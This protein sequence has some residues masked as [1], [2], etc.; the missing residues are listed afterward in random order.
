MQGA[1]IAGIAPGEEMS[2]SPGNTEAAPVALFAAPRVAVERRTDGTILLRSPIPLRPPARCLGDWLV[3][4]AGRAPDRTF[5]AERPPGGG[6]WI[7]V[8]YGA[9]LDRV[10]AIGAGLLA[11]G[12]SPERPLVVLSENG[13]THALLA[14]G[15]MHAGVPVAAVSP[16]YSLASRDH[17]A[18]GEMIAALDPGAIF[19]AD[20]VAYGPA[21]RAI[22]GRHRAAILVD[23]PAIDSAIPVAALEATRAGPALDDAFAAIGGET[24]ARLLFTSGSTGAPKAVVN[25]HRMLTANQEGKA[26]LWPFLEAAPPVIL[27]WLP[28]SHTFGA[29]HNLNLVLR[30]GGTLYID[31]GKPAP[32]LFKTSLDNLRDVEPSIMF[33]V[34]AGYDMLMAALRDDAALARRFFGGVQVL[35]YAGAALPQHL[36]DGLRDLS[37]RTIGRPLPMVSGWGS[38]ETAPMAMDCHFQAERS[39]NIGLPIPGCEVKLVPSGDKLEI[40][41]RGINVT[42]GYWRRPDL[43]A[44]AFDEEGFYRIGDAVRFADPA[45]PEQGLMFD[46]RVAE[47]FKLTTGTW[48]SVGTLRP[49]A[50]GFL[51]PVAQD[52]V[53]TGHDRGEVGFLVVPNVAAC[54]QLSG[55]PE[56]AA[57]RDVLGHPTV[58]SAVAAGLARLK[59][60]SG[61]SAGHATRALLMDE[62]PS[63]DAGE[64]TDK[65]YINQ[66]AVLARRADLVTR[67]YDPSFD[68]RI[69]LPAP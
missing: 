58:R 40:R 57:V 51:A 18:L 60:E 13:I 46:G 52:L 39:G 62:P 7:T 10:R 21:L 14:F 27:D 5:L 25:T 31:R 15:A 8:G 53:V 37:I 12:L 26:Q 47:D 3:A 44:A 36:W 30:N 45:R 2:G 50:I 20:P 55:L 9:A 63:V 69:D 23:G 66:R 33:N 56:G 35:F 43:T 41:V 4:W 16:A 42:P 17:V 11:L 67:L 64:I 29:N 34:P 65:G 54:R 49:R 61:G 28:W 22:A 6:D 48:V 59:A 24:I 68:G 19:A 1:T 32:H 38:T